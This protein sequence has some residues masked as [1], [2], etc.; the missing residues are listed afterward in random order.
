MV[1]KFA[2]VLVVLELGINN[3]FYHSFKISV[4]GNEMAVI[5]GFQKFE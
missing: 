3:S 1:L 4:A 5:K 2:G